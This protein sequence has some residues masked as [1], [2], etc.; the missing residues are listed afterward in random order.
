VPRVSTRISLRLPLRASS[1]LSLDASPRTLP[2]TL[3]RVLLCTLLYLLLAL[4]TYGCTDSPVQERAAG[5]SPSDSSTANPESVVVVAGNH[6]NAPRAGH[7][8]A[9][10]ELLDTAARTRGYVAFVCVDGQP[11]IFDGGGAVVGSDAPTERIRNEENA[12]WVSGLLSL[13]DTEVKAL[14][15]ESDPLSALRLATRA[16]E[17][18]PVGPRHIVV[19]D[20]GLATCAPAMFTQ[21]GML[22]AY[23]QD[24]AD[25][26]EAIDALVSFA[27]DVSIDWFGIGDVAAPQEAL[28]N[29]QRENLKSIWEAIITRG[30][31]RVVFHDDAP[32]TTVVNGLPA[33]SVVEIETEPLPELIEADEP[34]FLSEDVLHF[35]PN[36]AD[37]IDPQQARRVLEPYANYLAEHPD[38]YL[39]V[40]GTTAE[41]GWPTDDP[42]SVKASYDLSWSRAGVVAQ[43]L[44]ELGAPEAQVIPEGQGFFDQWHEQ[45]TDANGNYL[46]DAAARNRKVVLIPAN[47][48]H[49][50]V[51]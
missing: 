48:P 25:Y 41:G 43:L 44:I 32:E 8:P 15:P 18:A 50:C 5:A 28:T 37:F 39:H 17:S 2:H 24:V 10:V 3:V 9:L 11:F 35:V 22:F 47:T 12:A 45:E 31:G 6:A 23:P 21:E 49:A 4:G 38:L 13:M 30:G 29:H 40:V 33:V 20:S 19:V 7:Y 1:K 46:P 27:P 34:I 26:L 51:L 16:L 14:V 36:Y 42:A